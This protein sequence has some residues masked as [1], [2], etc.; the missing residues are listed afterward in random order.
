MRRMTLQKYISRL[1]AV[2]L[3]LTLLLACV[4]AAYAAESG[5]CGES[6]SWTFNAG[7]LTI[8]GSGSMTNFPES[9]M[10][11]WYAYRKDIV[12]LELPEGLTNIGDLAFYDCENL[13]AAV[14]PN[15]VTAIG[16]FAFTNCKSM[17]L[18]TIGSG[19]RSIGEAAFS[20]CY[21]LKLLELPSG[22]TSIGTK[23][24]YRCESVTSVTVPSSV[25]SMGV[26]VFAYCKDLV[27]ANVQASL[28]VLPEYTFYQCEN[29][30][31]VVLPD[32]TEDVST[33][34]FHG[35]EQ[36]N[37]VYYGGSAKK[38]E[39][40]Q[41]SIG[42]G[43][44]TDEPPVQEP[45]TS[46]N[47]QLN[48]DGSM[49]QEEI[50]LTPGENSSVS[51]KTESTLMPDG[52]TTSSNTQIDVTINGSDGWKEATNAVEKELESL[53]EDTEKVTVNVVVKESDEIDSGFV[54]SMADKNVT[55][56]ITTQSGSSWKFQGN[57]LH[58]DASA[59]SYNFSYTL[60]EGNQELCQQLNASAGFFL[61]FHESAQVNAEV[62]IHLGSGC[63][64]Q[65]ATLFQ[66]EKGDCVQIQ[67]VVVDA[68]GYAHFYLGSVDKNME[69]LI[70]INVQ[71]EESVQPLIPEGLYQNTTLID[72]ETG[73]EYA[74][75]GRTSSWNMGL[76]K[77]MGIL[78]GVML[79]VI[80]LI[81]GIMFLWNKKR[82]EA[83]YV[84]DWDDAE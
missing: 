57:H 59:E 1:M 13:T 42:N 24:F 71:A 48:P 21:S 41:T 19:V 6:L 72:Q 74:I 8:T 44:V 81:G 3:C 75:T 55:V 52:T 25:T 4:P 58:S 79:G 20:D 28:R 62:L 82:L 66:R 2:L 69:Y 83:G 26:S 64:Y 9:S 63:A 10:A 22:L 27:S 39:E 11:P 17:Q 70:G 36:L 49:Q 23:A 32:N 61:S 78:A 45:V 47:V 56:T 14:I 68:N 16:R 7:T 31:S 67:T 51:T 18:L 84:P 54:E 65:Q 15:S 80:V 29:L 30:S 33:F 46:G 37:T 76:G 35:C 73:Q 60:T 53:P 50:T 34:S 43:I 77:V 5:S 40:L 38:P 12:R